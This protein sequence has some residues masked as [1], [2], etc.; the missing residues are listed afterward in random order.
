ML[1]TTTTVKS[2]LRNWKN[3]ERE[4]ERENEGRIDEETGHHWH[5]Y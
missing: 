4:R 3:K 2:D 1:S 5:I